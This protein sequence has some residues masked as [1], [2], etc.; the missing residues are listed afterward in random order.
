MDPNP[1]HLAA[2]VPTCSP[3][4]PVLVTHGQKPVMFAGRVTYFRQFLP[5][6]VAMSLEPLSFAVFVAYFRHPLP[7]GPL[8]YRF[9]RKRHVLVWKVI[10]LVTVFTPFLERFDSN[11]FVFRAQE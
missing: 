3:Q 5:A 2:H 4:L 7:I 6:L 1:D 11:L 8:G 9:S 10:K